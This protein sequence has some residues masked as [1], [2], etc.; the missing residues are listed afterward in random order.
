N[1]L[2][3]HA[4]L[5][6]I[7]GRAHAPQALNWHRRIVELAPNSKNKLLLA[8][9]ALR[10]QPAPFTLAADILNELSNSPPLSV[11]FHQVCAE[12]FLR[13]NDSQGAERQF[14]AA[15]R[16]EPTNVI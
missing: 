5:V 9:A 2:R 16:L 12:L 7:G 14:E 6:H 10:L 11:Q 4:D 15:A 1:Q 8:D 3:G 13:L